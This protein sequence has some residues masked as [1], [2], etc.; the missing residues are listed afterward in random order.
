MEVLQHGM[1]ECMIV[2]AAHWQVFERGQSFKCIHRHCSNVIATKNPA[3]LTNT[4]TFTY[5]NYY[6]FHHMTMLEVKYVWKSDYFRY[7]TIL[8]T[9]RS[10]YV[11]CWMH[12]LP[13]LLFCCCACTCTGNRYG[14]KIEPRPLFAARPRGA[15]GGAQR[16]NKRLLSVHKSCQQSHTQRMHWAY[17]LDVCLGILGT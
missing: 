10:G 17:N 5:I 11:V 15:G 8:H 9:D 1:T 16:V 6:L 3:K 13:E 12:W 2:H 4:L 7:T 14:S